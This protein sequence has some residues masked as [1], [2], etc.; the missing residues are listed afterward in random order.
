MSTTDG[1]TSEEG[2][3]WSY[4]IRLREEEREVLF[5]AAKLKGRTPTS[6]IKQAAMERAIH[7]V[8]T[9]RPNRFNFEAIARHLAQ[10]LSTEPMVELERYDGTK[11]QDLD[12]LSVTSITKPPFDE[13]DWSQFSEAVRLGGFEFITKLTD[14]WALLCRSRWHLPPPIDPERFRETVHEASAPSEETNDSK[15]N[16]LDGQDRR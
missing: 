1:P 8:N 2:K 4:A 7:T 5:E 12:D 16:T 3:T 14:E 13:S 9:C 6:L 11:V 10:K 15:G